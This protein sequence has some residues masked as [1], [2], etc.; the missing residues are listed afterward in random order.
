VCPKLDPSTQAKGLLGGAACGKKVLTSL[1]GQIVPAFWISGLKLEEQAAK[2][3]QDVLVLHGLL[4]R[5]EFPGVN[6]QI[7]EL[8]RGL[9]PGVQNTGDPADY[10]FSGLCCPGMLILYCS[11]LSSCVGDPGGCL[12]C[13]CSIELACGTSPLHEEQHL[14]P[15][16]LWQL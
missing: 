13:I 10:C 8:G 1:R 9:I 15:G 4:L 7:H 16:S 12:G 2:L 11:T 3:G 5:W 14:S 6:A